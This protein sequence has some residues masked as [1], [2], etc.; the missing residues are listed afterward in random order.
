MQ[1]LFALVALCLQKPLQ[2]ERRFCKGLKT[3]WSDVYQLY[4]RASAQALQ[5]IATVVGST[6]FEDLERSEFL[7]GDIL[8]AR[9]E[10]ATAAAKMAA[11]GAAEP[12]LLAATLADIDAD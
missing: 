3:A 7:N 2:S 9:S 1:T 5:L 8:T 10:A 6:P 11:I 12:A 4:A